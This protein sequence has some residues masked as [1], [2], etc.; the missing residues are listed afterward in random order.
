MSAIIFYKRPDGKKPARDWLNVQDNSIKPNIYRKLDDL[1][2]N[3]LDLVNTNAMDVI[4]G[5]DNGFYELRNRG[6]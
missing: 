3:G 4:S 5:P 2:S 6:L 1:K